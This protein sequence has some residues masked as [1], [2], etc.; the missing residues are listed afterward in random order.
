M[1]P[2]IWVLLNVGQNEYNQYC[3]KALLNPLGSVISDKYTNDERQ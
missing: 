3:M 2:F 1:F